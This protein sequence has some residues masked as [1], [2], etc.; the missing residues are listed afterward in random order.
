MLE[1]FGV[2]EKDAWECLSG[3]VDTTAY[4]RWVEGLSTQKRRERLREQGQRMAEVSAFVDKVMDQG[5]WRSTD[6]G[7]ES[8]DIV[9][10]ITQQADRNSR[11]CYRTA[12]N[13]IKAAWDYEDRVSYCEGYVLPKHGVRASPHAWLEIDGSVFELTW[14]WHA[15]V[16]NDAVYYGMEIPR[17]LLEERM[18]ERIGG[19]PMSLTADEWETDLNK[20]L[21]AL[22]K[23]PAAT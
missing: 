21:K 10:E 3:S 19:N 16:D 2:A 6:L 4:E 1:L 8:A 13:A 5:E 20:S 12:Q 11:R 9:R 17:E 7:S 23:K 18:D 22:G 15:P 14:P